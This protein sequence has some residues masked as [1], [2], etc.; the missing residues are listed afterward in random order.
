[1]KAYLLGKPI[2]VSQ[3]S[4]MT[5]KLISLSINFIFL[6][7]CGQTGELYIP[8]DIELNSNSFNTQEHATYTPLDG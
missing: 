5:N 3:K 8:E 4:T 6:I 2:E 1:M 7:S